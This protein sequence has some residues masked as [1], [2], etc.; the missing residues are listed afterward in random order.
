MFFISPLLYL[1]NTTHTPFFLAHFT[2]FHY[3]YIC[4]FYSG[5]SSLNKAYDMISGFIIL[6]YRNHPRAWAGG[7]RWQDV[8]TK[9]IACDYIHMFIHMI[10]YYGER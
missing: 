3:E 7:G 10:S 9:K 6:C 5:A 4:E 1:R 2:F 8:T